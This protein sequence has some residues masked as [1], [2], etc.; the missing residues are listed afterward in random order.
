MRKDIYRFLTV[1][2]AGLFFCGMALAQQ[3]SAPSTQ[4]PSSSKPA[5][6]A[7]KKTTPAAAPKPK[8]F[9]LDND[10]DKASY[11]I[12]LN[13]GRSMKKDGVEV[14]AE[15][16]T[17]GIKDAIGDGKALLTDEEITAVLTKLQADVRKHQQETFNAALTKNKEE[18]DAFLAANKAKPDVTTLPD[19]LQY[20][21]LQAGDGPKPTAADNVVCN[22]RGTL[23]DG[24]EFDSSYKRGKPATF[25]VSQVIKGWTEA[26]QLMP[27][28]S[29]WQIYIPS[30]LAYGERGTQ[31]GPIGPNATLIFDLELVSIQPKPT[32]KLESVPPS[33]VPQ[34]QAAPQDKPQAAP[35]TQPQ[36]KQQ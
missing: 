32:P 7:P 9:T 2:A 23:I 35:Q 36:P 28:G 10:T 26:L 22:Y 25:G 12:G 24:T 20:K 4:Q 15:A 14:N 34:P 31:G 1:P 21:I 27:V 33:G 8:P 17:K 19:G 29:K 16:L 30:N 6:T 18:G 11:A 5:T 13:I 3:S